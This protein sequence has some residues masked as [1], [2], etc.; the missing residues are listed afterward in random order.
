MSS[1]ALGCPCYTSDYSA[2]MDL[3]GCCLRIQSRLCKVASMITSLLNTLG[4]CY[5]DCGHIPYKHCSVKVTDE[6]LIE[7][8]ALK[9][10]SGAAKHNR[11]ES[12]SRHRFGHAHCFYMYADQRA[13]ACA[14]LMESFLRRA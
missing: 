4:L 8:Q 7:N 9:V 14:D 11:V 2:S 12:T 5:T 10:Q 1:N 3:S 13:E 6:E